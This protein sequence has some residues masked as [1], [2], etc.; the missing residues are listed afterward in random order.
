M[1]AMVWKR[2]LT[3]LK[4]GNLKL[5]MS[6]IS[7]SPTL[8]L[9]VRGESTL[10]TVLNPPTIPLF[11]LIRTI[12]SLIRPWFAVA[13]NVMN[14]VAPCA[15]SLISTPTSVTLYTFQSKSFL[16]VQI[17]VPRPILSISLSSVAMLF[18][19]NSV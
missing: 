1:L 2:E 13:V 19:S 14:P 18:K 7:F 15:T 16:A 10:S 12:S 6:S 5:V 11:V 9:K 17:V 4:I 3:S 8:M